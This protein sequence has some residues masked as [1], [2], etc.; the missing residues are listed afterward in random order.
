M[1]AQA[2]SAGVLSVPHSISQSACVFIM[3]MFII[4]NLRFSRLNWSRSVKAHSAKSRQQQKEGSRTFVIVLFF[5]F[6]KIQV[7]FIILRRYLSGQNKLVRLSLI[8]FNPCR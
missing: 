5:S 8:I 7:L 6:F 2:E 3:L 1:H 4:L